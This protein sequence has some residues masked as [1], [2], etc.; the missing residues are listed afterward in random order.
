MVKA[1]SWRLETEYPCSGVGES[2]T[3]WIMENPDKKIISHAH[4]QIISSGSYLAAALS[5]YIIISVVYE[6]GKT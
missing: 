3:T 5:G 6:D 2:I 4:C 1:E